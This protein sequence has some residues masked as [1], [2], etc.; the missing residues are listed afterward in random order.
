MI[1][2]FH[3]TPQLVLVG[4]LLQGLSL[5]SVDM[6]DSRAVVG[7]TQRAAHFWC[8]WRCLKIDEICNLLWV[9]QDAVIGE[10]VPKELQ[11]V[12]SELARGLVQGQTLL[13]KW[14]E[15]GLQALVVF[16]RGFS[17]H[18][19]VITDVDC[20]VNIL[21]R[22]VDY[23]LKISAALKRPKLRRL[24]LKRAKC[25]LKVVTYLD[26]GASSSSL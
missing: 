15:Y 3:P 17:K 1:M 4:K 13:S 10:H 9:W 8:C 2:F 12:F 26:S 5:G 19:N 6:D 21:E 7:H 14:L 25:V 16:F 20:P 23:V 22:L 11:L 24:Y 18:W